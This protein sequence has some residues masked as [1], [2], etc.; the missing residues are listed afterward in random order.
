M[1]LTIK[2]VAI[3]AFA[4]AA[5]GSPLTTFGKRTPVL[6]TPSKEPD[7]YQPFQTQLP[8][9]LELPKEEANPVPFYAPEPSTDLKAPQEFQEPD[10][11]QVPIPNQELA[12]PID[13]EWNPNN[14]PI[15]Y[16]EV[17]A[18]INNQESPTREFPKKYNEDIHDKKKPFASQPKVEIIFEPISKQQYEEK[19]IELTKKPTAGLPKYLDTVT[20][21]SDQVESA[22]ATFDHGLSS[23]LTASLG[24]PSSAPTHEGASQGERLEF[25]MVG[26]DGPLSYKWGYDTGKGHNR[27]FRFEERDKEGVVKGHYGFYDKEGK[28]QVVHY[29]AHPHTGFHVAENS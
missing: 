2:L 28:L 13:T 26:H 12:A 3:F 10:Y 19:Q 5:T 6:P 23:Q 24:I 25:H 14:D 16:Y 18:I 21:S 9:E 29:D 8:M 7:S 17:P 4:A 27:L 1:T 20:T 11:Y 15:Y 22:S